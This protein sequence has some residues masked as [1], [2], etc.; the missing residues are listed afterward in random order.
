[1]GGSGGGD[2][3]TANPFV[4]PEPVRAAIESHPTVNGDDGRSPSESSPREVARLANVV[5][6]VVTPVV[7]R[8][9]ET[10]WAFPVPFVLAITT[11]D[12]DVPFANSS[13]SR[14]SSSAV[15]WMYEAGGRGKSGGGV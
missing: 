1:M 13:C 9:S 5:G 4:V 6:E 10:T 14:A 7:D 3:G 15:S 12:D 11:D 8:V 2:D